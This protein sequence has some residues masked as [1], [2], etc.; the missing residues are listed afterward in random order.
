MNGALRSSWLLLAD[1]N[2]RRAGGRGI[3][4]IDA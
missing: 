4:P 3:S 1:K 2:T